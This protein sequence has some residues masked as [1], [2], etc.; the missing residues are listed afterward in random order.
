MVDQ[1]Y[2]METSRVTLASGTV[3]VGCPHDTEEYRATA[4]SLGY[5]DDTVAM[6]RDH[7]PLHQAL[8]SWLG[9]GESF[10]LRCAAGERR[11]DELSAAEEAA[12]M[13]VQR[14]AK[15]AGARL[16]RFARKGD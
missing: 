1:E 11:E 10:A 8:C 3:V 4:A 14:F 6:C 9:V 7:D 13:A 2:A 5:G 15:L 12:V 16:P